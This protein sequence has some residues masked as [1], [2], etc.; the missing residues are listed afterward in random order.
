MLFHCE[1]QQVVRN[2]ETVPDGIVNL[3]FR[4]EIR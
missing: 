3:I 2:R 4:V 1:G